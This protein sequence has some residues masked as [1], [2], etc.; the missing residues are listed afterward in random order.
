MVLWVTSNPTV[1]LG[2]GAIGDAP[3]DGVLVG[4]IPLGGELVN[5]RHSLGA[6]PVLQA[7]IAARRADPGSSM[8]VAAASA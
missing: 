6:G 3:A 8:S 2:L 5:E 7:E 4:E 1:R